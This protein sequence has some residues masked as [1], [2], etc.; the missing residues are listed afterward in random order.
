MGFKS[1]VLSKIQAI[2]GA[3]KNHPFSH[4]KNLKVVNRRYLQ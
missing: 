1:K 2:T 4:C 3:L